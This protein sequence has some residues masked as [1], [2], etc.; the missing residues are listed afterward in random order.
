LTKLSEHSAGQELATVFEGRLNYV[1]RIPQNTSSN[2]VLVKG[3]TY[4]E[5]KRLTDAINRNETKGQAL[6]K[7]IGSSGA[8]P[9]PPCR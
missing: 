2:F 9:M 1:E 7:E 3:L 6:K 8:D 5:A 4:N